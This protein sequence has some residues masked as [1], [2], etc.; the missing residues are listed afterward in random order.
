MAR[1]HL[2]QHLPQ[3]ATRTAVA[4][5]HELLLELNVGP[6]AV[7]LIT[8][9][10]MHQ[11]HLLATVEMGQGILLA[12]HAPQPGTGP[13][14]RLAKEQASQFP[15]VVLTMGGDTVDAVVHQEMI[16]GALHEMA[17]HF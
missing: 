6:Q 11:P 2:G 8:P 17:C 4:D 9:Y 13:K 15:R 5:G 1:V 14:G 12:D 16:T 3:A 7:D 10:E